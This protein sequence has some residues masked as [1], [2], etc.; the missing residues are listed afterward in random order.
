MSM[1]S[2]ELT[3]WMA[4]EQSN[5]PLGQRRQDIQAATVA[6]T[7]ANAATGRKKRYRIS[8][9]L[10]PYNKHKRQQTPYEMLNSIRH[11]TR[12]TGGTVRESEVN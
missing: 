3:E 1:S 2:Y 5:G 10:V 8:D 6:A 4:Y 9:F 12:R 7:I 11:I